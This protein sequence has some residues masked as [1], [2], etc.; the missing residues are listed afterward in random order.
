M[1]IRYIELGEEPSDPKEATQVRRCASSYWIIE[2]K[3]YGRGFSVL[4]LKCIEG[5]E[6][7]YGLSEIHE[8]I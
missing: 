3:L 2:G 6:S 1:I 4:Q 8:G 7:D 5:D